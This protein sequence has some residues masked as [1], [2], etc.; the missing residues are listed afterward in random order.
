MTVKMYSSAMDKNFQVT[1][2]TPFTRLTVLIFLM[3]AAKRADFF[4]T[5]AANDGVQKRCSR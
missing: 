1:K 4:T 2:T 5:F 3:L